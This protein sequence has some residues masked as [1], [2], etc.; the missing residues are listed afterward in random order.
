[1]TNS[2][3]FTIHL[4]QYKLKRLALDAAVTAGMEI[5]EDNYGQIVIYTGLQEDVDEETNTLMI[6]DFEA[7]EA[8][9][10]EAFNRERK[11]RIARYH[12]V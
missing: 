8:E 5:E 3:E 10:Q 12:G 6:Q 9:D 2:P 4:L 1:M 11:E 7:D